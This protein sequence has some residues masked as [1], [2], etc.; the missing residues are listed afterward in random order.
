[1]KVLLSSV[2][3]P[4]GVDDAYGR[5][6]N[7]M[8]LFH[9]QVTREQGLFS[10]RFH[11]QSFG[12]YFLAENINAPTTV[13]DFPSEKRFVKEIMK[14]YDY[15]GISFIVTNFLKAK[16]MAE[17]IRKYAPQSKIIFGGHGT[18]I[19]GIENIIEHDYICRGEG[20]KWLRRLLG[21]NV[22]R[23]INHPSISSASS[24]HVVGLPMKI[25]SGIIIPGV[26]CPNACRF[27]ATSHFFG[28]KY[29]PYIDTGKELFDIC[30]KIEKTK[31][32]TQF[33]I[34]DE[35]FLKRPERARELLRLMEEQDKFYQFGIFSSAE[36][37][38]Q[39][40][41]EFL[42]R[43]G[44]TFL[45]IGVESKHEIY[46][47][48]RGIELKPMIQE[49]RS[50]GISVLS[51]GILFL[52]HHD[53]N[54]IWEDVE[55]IVDLESDAVQFMELGPMPGTKLYRD[56][57]Q[58]G[59]LLKH[60]P[61]EEWHGQHQ[62]WFSHPH[63]SQQESELFLRQA[64]QYDYNT[65]GS[66]LLRMCDTVIRGYNTLARY[67]DPYMM[68]RREIIKKQAEHYRQVLA[69]LKQY[70]H[71]DYV[72]SLTKEV[73]EKYDAKLGPM[74]FRQKLISKIVSLYASREFVRV[75]EGKNVYQPK[76]KVFNYR[77]SVR[78][79]AVDSL[80]GKNFANILKIQLNWEQDPIQVELV[81]TMDKVNAKT[82][83]NNILGY[84]QR[85]DSSVQLNLKDL[86]SIEDESL[87]QLL[88]K[89][90]KYYRRVQIVSNELA[91]TANEAISMLPDRLSE[92]FIKNDLL[93]PVF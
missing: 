78:D 41:V 15:I 60:I 72:R 58:K 67:D 36:T 7:I 80:K 51:S 43:L 48:N 92:L 66:T 25:D 88:T 3:G 61:Y 46:E 16:R 79:L 11:N 89:L 21:E 50:H 85:K 23:P 19:P 40:G 5:K 18:S 35:N 6:E 24:K 90:K 57:D 54:T 69:V 2:F 20:V 65:K 45:W 38:K 70:A 37:I 76:T 63:F 39:M 64:F 75:A 74:S 55:F 91:Q 81:G 33:F 68:T 22:E 62:I 53:Q 52:E 17:L 31:G 47:K 10:L 87:K 77:R 44:V 84:L 8:E 4:Y 93:K 13:L 71:N 30:V 73:I 32:Y 27:C 26:G 83:A 86:L 28:K 14:G 56:Y 42:A 59:I 9:N 12:L 49:L 1:M 82:L 34:M 29:V